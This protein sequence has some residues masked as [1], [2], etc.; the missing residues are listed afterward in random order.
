MRDPLGGIID[1]QPYPHLV[2]LLDCHDK[3][4]L[5]IILKAKQLCITWLMAGADLHLATFK[6]GA[7]IITLSKGQDEAAESLDY[8]R[9]LHSQLPD[10]LRISL[11]KDQGGLLTFPS[12]HSKIR[13]LPSTPDTG[14]GFGG[15]T[16]VVLD[17]FEYHNYDERNYGELKPMID[18][19]G[20][21]VILSTADQWRKESKFK[22]L[23]KQA[24]VGDNN[25]F[26]IFPPYNLMPY[27][28]EEWRNNL[29]KDHPAWQVDCHYPRNEQDALSTLKTFPLF[30]PAKLDLC[31]DY[32][33]PMEHDLSDKYIGMVKIYRPSVVGEKYCVATDPSDGKED[34]HAIIVLKVRTGEQV[35]ES[36]GKVTADRCAQIHDD[37]VRYYNNA[38]N[39]YELN[40]RAG[41]IFS[42][43]MKDLDTPNQ[44]GFLKTDGKLDN[45]RHG[46]WTGETL[47]RTFYGGLEE[48]IRLREVIIHNPDITKELG[49]IIEPEGEMAQA[50]QGGHNDYLDALSRA[51]HLKRY[52][53]I[54]EMRVICFPMRE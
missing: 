20:Q 17:E 41:G 18:R 42:Q 47:K 38:L 33:K 3:H 54:G 5:I 7:N 51:W 4:Q 12:V 6:E 31:L 46:W 39:T 50:P 14:V 52:C 15:A 45:K 36:H 40:A 22:E 29:Y 11:G 24:K 27:R 34:P 19:G 16:R 23:Y 35:A 1:W 32:L 37:L 26:P 10:F 48:A 2:Y 21:L 44:C 53:P 28:S 49:E 8:T 13:A 25:F 9:F 43:K 30:A